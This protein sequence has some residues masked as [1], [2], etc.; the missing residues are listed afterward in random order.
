MKGLSYTS[1]RPYSATVAFTI[2]STSRARLTSA[3]I[4]TALPPFCRI[5]A[6]VSIPP[7]QPLSLVAHLVSSQRKR[8]RRPL[9]HM[10]KKLLDRVRMMIRLRCKLC[11]AGDGMKQASAIV[12]DATESL[13]TTSCGSNVIAFSPSTLIGI[14]LGTFMSYNW[15]RRETIVDKRHVSAAAGRKAC[16]WNRLTCHEKSLAHSNCAEFPFICTLLVPPS[17]V[18]NKNP[19]WISIIAPSS[20]QVCNS[21]RMVACCPSKV[22]LNT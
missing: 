16:R 5:K 4:Y 12:T 13:L 19:F 6:S 14:H 20:Q 9:A 15:Y 22:S 8:E 18:L 11:L 21:R 2:S 10:P 17:T 7:A 1:M 3:L